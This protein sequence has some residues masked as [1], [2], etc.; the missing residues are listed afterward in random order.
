MGTGS[1]V[2]KLGRDSPRTYEDLQRT[3]EPCSLLKMK[4]YKEVIRP[5]KRNNGLQDLETARRLV[6]IMK[7]SENARNLNYPD[8]RADKTCRIK[9]NGIQDP[10]ALCTEI[11]RR[12]P[13]EPQ[14][15]ISA[16]GLENSRNP[17]NPQPPPR[18]LVSF[19]NSNRETVTEYPVQRQNNRSCYDVRHEKQT[20]PRTQSSENYQIPVTN[21]IRNQSEFGFHR[22]QPDHYQEYHQY[23]RNAKN[24]TGGGGDVSCLE[25]SDKQENV[26]LN[27]NGDAP[28]L[29][30]DASN[31]D[32]QVMQNKVAFQLGIQEARIIGGITYLARKP[33]YVP[34]PYLSSTPNIQPPLIQ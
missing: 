17:D 19:N 4:I 29:H 9:L 18:R 12:P 15:R 13:V 30:A 26:N 20:V 21:R 3:S 32:C 23:L 22:L 1:A 28:T 34:E 2:A 14:R 7:N 31:G 8:G 11:E 25:K 6:E 16:N 24:I 5:Q 27:C 10:D 33:S